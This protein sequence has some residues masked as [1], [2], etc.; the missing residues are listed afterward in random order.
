M[1]F[2]ED[3]RQLIYLSPLAHSKFS[4][5]VHTS[6]LIIQSHDDRGARVLIV[7]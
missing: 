3:S 6:A 4:A 7:N 1:T 2:I 5:L